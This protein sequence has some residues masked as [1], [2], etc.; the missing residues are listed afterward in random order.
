MARNRTTKLTEFGLA[1][2]VRKGMGVGRGRGYYN[3]APQDSYI[4]Y[5]SGK[6]IRIKQPVFQKLPM[7]H[8][9]LELTLYVP[10]TQGESEL[11]TPKKFDKRITEAELKMSELFGGY[12]Q[13]DTQGG[14]VGERGLVREPVAKVTS[15]TTIKDFEK[16]K[17]EFEG[18]VEEIRGKY[19]QESMSIE[20]EGDL[21]FYEPQKDT[22]G[23]GVP[24][25]DD[26]SP[27]DPTKQDLAKNFE[28][29]IKELRWYVSNFTSPPLSEFSNDYFFKNQLKRYPNQTDRDRDGVP[30]EIDLE[31]KR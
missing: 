23:D 10:S 1:V 9:P 18:Y 15:F 26:C 12:T 22:D 16:N 21:Y 8:N 5:L 20:F 14:W 3:I 2:P 24:D 19:G 17:A 6:G 4:H 30:D 27:L 25:I 7:G 28:K 31:I 29:P 11:I 13:V